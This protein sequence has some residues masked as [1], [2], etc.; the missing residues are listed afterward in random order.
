MPAR[1]SYTV[2]YNP[3]AEDGADYYTLEE[4]LSMTPIYSKGKTSKE[5]QVNPNYKKP[6]DF[7]TANYFVALL[8]HRASQC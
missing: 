2:D 7:E 8:N 3:F 4:D 1:Y 5:D 6:G